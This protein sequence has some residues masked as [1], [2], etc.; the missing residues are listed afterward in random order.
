MIEVLRR[1]Q[2]WGGGIIQSLNLTL[3]L[4]R[5]W[6]YGRS[7]FWP[8]PRTGTILGG[9]NPASSGR[10]WTMGRPG[11]GSNQWHQPPAVLSQPPELRTASTN[12]LGGA[13]ND[14]TGRLRSLGEML[15]VSF[16]TPSPIRKRCRVVRRFSGIICI[17]AYD[18]AITINIWSGDQSICVIHCTALYLYKCNS[19]TDFFLF[20]TP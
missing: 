9:G 18:D 15:S 7:M 1:N 6:D 16:Q 12:T 13:R 2:Q 19:A 4:C 8:L 11:K 3:M 20:K 5:C 14:E 10:N 17:R